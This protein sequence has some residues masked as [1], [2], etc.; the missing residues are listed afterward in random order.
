MEI[1]D[2]KRALSI[3]EV[4]GYYGLTPD[5]NG[6]ICCPFHEDKTPSMQIYP[7]TDTA[8]C[9][10]SN[11]KLHAKAIDQIDFI[12][13]K[14]GI[15]KHMA[16]KKAKGMVVSGDIEPKRNKPTIMTPNPPESLTKLF[17]TLRQKYYRGTLAQEYAKQRHLDYK[18]LELGFNPYSNTLMTS[19]KNCLVFPLKDVDDEIVSFYGR[20]IAKNPRSK[21]FYMKNRSGLYPGY[22]STAIKRL[23]IVEAPIDAATIQS[24]TKYTVLSLYGTNGWTEEHT[25]S[26]KRIEELEEVV[27][28]MDG[29]EAGQKAIETYSGIL[30]VLKPAITISRVAT[31]K[32][33]DVN[34]LLDAHPITVGT[35]EANILLHL[36]DAREILHGSRSLDTKKSDHFLFLPTEAAA[37]AGSSETE[38]SGSIDR[39]ISSEEKK[40]PLREGLNQV[41]ASPQNIAQENK[42]STLLDLDDTEPEFIKWQHE[43]LQFKVLGK[44]S[45][46]PVDKLVQTLE[47][48]KQQSE[49]PRHKIRQRINLYDD[50]KL[51]KLADKIADRM[52]LSMNSVHGSMIRL[53]DLLS[54]YRTGQIKL[55]SESE[56]EIA[57]MSIERRKEIL[58]FAKQPGLIKRVNE[59]IGKTG[60]VGEERNRMILWLIYTSR[61]RKEPLHVMCLGASGTGKTYLQEKVSALIPEE[62]KIE[63]TA[64]SDNSVYYF[65]RE[66]LK[67]KLVLIE[68]LDGANEE[69]VMYALRE[70]MSKTRISKKVVIKDNQGRMRTITLKVEGPICLSGTTTR[71]SLYEDNANRSILIYLDQSMKQRKRIM[72]YQCKK[73]ANQI[74]RKEQEEIKLFLQDLQRIYKHVEVVNPYA[75]D[76]NLPDQVFKPLRTNKHYL[77][78][79]ETITFVHQY[80]RARKRH[81]D[82]TYY[83]ETTIEDIQIANA[84]IHEVLLAK[85]DELTKACRDFFERVK[86]WMIAEEKSTFYRHQIRVA[87]RMNPNNVKYYLQ[88]LT[89]YGLVKIVGGNRYKSGYE[90]EV[91]NVEEY[92]E[93]SG[94]LKN[95]LEVNLSKIKTKYGI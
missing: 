71:E 61:L 78:V 55:D 93:L 43:Q 75:M 16:I 4:I 3:R 68:D 57:P 74:N 89:N 26:I 54:E 29:D 51:E 30:R 76:I 36:I 94:K 27:F 22:P 82:G 44:V 10:S 58:A 81:A 48:S 92:K 37:Q 79:I 9:F 15:S 84:L 47:V 18:K 91:I 35:D 69:K 63:I 80:Q 5:R 21:H 62:D 95:A 34:S 24:H 19:L 87:F 85:S 42:E 77:E 73:S 45:L 65:D 67:N 46:F 70:L 7:N 12:M 88:Q 40:K 90:Y 41:S 60:L 59:L 32:G 56:P 53:T 11:C 2:I 28:F 13:Y 50:D 49:D 14:E 23:I 52:D 6:R 72:E 86:R 17:K 66:E 25:E 8:Y 20:S 38:K 1:L 64:M 39:K 83:I 33:E 31:P